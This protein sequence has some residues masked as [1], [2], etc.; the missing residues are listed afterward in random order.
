LQSA[1]T[2]SKST[3]DASTWDDS[4]DFGDSDRGGYGLRKDHGLSSF[5]V[6]NAWTANFTVDLPNRG[7]GGLAGALLG[8]WRLSGVLRFNDGFPLNPTAQQPRN[9]IRINGVNT[10]FSMSFVD[11]PMLDLVPGGDQNRVRPQH[12]DEYIDVSQFMLPATN[13]LSRDPRNDTPEPFP[14]QPALTGG[15]A[16]PEGAFLGNLGRN[17]LISPGV[18]NVDLALRKEASMDF[19]GETSVLQFR[20]EFFNIFNRPNF[21]SPQM[22]LFTRTGAVQSGAGQ[23]Q[24]TSVN[25]RQAQLALRLM[26]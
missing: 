2:F 23:I 3:D 16:R 17:V 7:L 20:A 21:G 12:P 24:E 11:G 13:C 10:D 14:C 8:G 25:A 5:H 15:L 18:A 19:L 26:F 22:T 1:Y 9:R 6:R 4:R